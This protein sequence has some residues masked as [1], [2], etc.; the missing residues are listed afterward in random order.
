MRCRAKYPERSDEP[1]PESVVYDRKA[2]R[3]KVAFV[4]RLVAH[5]WRDRRL[6]L[7]G[8]RPHPLAPGGMAG[9]ANSRRAVGADC[10]WHRS[11]EAFAQKIG[12][13]AGASR[14][15]DYRGQQILG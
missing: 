3:G 12:Q 6:E 9:G 8:L 11:L 2:A 7:A 1:I 5:A 14:G 4:L 15:C 10:P 13:L